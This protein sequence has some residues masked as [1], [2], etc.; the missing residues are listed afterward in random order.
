MLKIASL[1]HPKGDIWDLRGE[2]EIAQIFISWTEQQGINSIQFLYVDKNNDYILSDRY[3]GNP[4]TKFKTVKLNPPSEFLTRL[5]GRNIGIGTDAEEGFVASSISFET[6]KNTYGPFGYRRRK[7]VTDTDTDT[8]DFQMGDDK[9]FA[10][11][12]GSTNFGCLESI[13]VYVKP[14]SKITKVEREE[15]HKPSR[16]IFFPC[17]KGIR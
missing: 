3:G 14:Q 4:G 10:G 1:M 7:L 15:D 11:F 13:G 9:Q 12:H 2:S 16:W 5:S 6:N 17:F 8:F